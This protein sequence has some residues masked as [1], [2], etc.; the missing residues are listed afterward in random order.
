MPASPEQHE[1]AV[2]RASK[3][4]AVIKQAAER[5]EAC[6][7]NAILAERFGCG[8][9]RICAAL[10]FLECAGMIEVERGNDR[11]VV[12]ICATGQKTAGTVGKPH[13]R[14]AA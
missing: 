9:A 1:H 2:Q 4:F 7:T 12:A 14:E 5:G 11:R 8:R 6:P 10:N 13:W 3:I